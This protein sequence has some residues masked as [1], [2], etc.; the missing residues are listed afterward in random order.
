[1]GFDRL[2]G[3][4]SWTSDCPSGY[5][6]HLASIDNGCEIHY[7]VRTGAFSRHKELELIRP[8][9]G[10]SYPRVLNNTI[11]TN[12]IKIPGAA[13]LRNFSTGRWELVPMPDYTTSYQTVEGPASAAMTSTDTGEAS[14]GASTNSDHSHRPGDSLPSHVVVGI[15]VGAAVVGFLLALLAMACRLKQKQRP[16]L[17]SVSK[18]QLASPLCS[19]VNPPYKRVDSQPLEEATGVF[20]TNPSTS[21]STRDQT[22]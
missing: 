10:R 17:C 7:C 4:K 12:M 2:E 11:N 20:Y 21:R 18:S 3:E 15:A 9:Y 5:S 16:R 1:M 14:V 22:P 8:P 6:Q 13:W 19:S